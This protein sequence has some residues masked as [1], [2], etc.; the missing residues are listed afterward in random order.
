MSK[1]LISTVLTESLYKSRREL[2]QRFLDLDYNIVLVG[3][4]YDNRIKEYFNIEYVVFYKVNFDRTGL[5]IKSDIETIKSLTKII[6]AEKPDLVYSFGGAKATIYTTMAGYF[7]KVNKIYCTINGL[8]SVYRS[9]NIRDQ[10]IKLVMNLLFKFSLSRANGVF[11]QNNDDLDVFTSKRLVV[12]NKCRIIN[13]SGVNLERF[14]YFEPSSER[15]AF[16]FVGRLIKDKGIYEFVE[17]AKKLKEEFTRVEFWIVGGYDSNP[18]AVSKE[19]IAEWH[20]KG[21]IRYFGY[22]DNVQDFYRLSSVF[23]LPSYHEGTPRTSLEAMAVGRPIITTNVP[24]CKETVIDGRNGFLVPVKDV[25]AL[26]EKMRYFI[27][28]TEKIIE[29]GIESY[30]IAE[31]KYDVNKVNDSILDFIFNSD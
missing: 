18:T 13:G 4:D 15:I 12:A 8:G 2:I 5:D 14:S 7:C 1:I 29:M 28:N 10:H 22:Q 26:V 27:L 19:K 31:D 20:D 23:V 6:R 24:G 3:P 11:F 30:R 25:N 17:A 21:Y 16:L 9:S